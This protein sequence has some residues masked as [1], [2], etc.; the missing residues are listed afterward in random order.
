MSSSPAWETVSETQ[1]HPVPTD[2][3]P[4][5]Q[6][7]MK[8]LRMELSSR[9]CYLEERGWGV[10]SGRVL[11]SMCETPCS[12]CV[13]APHSTP[14]PPRRQPQAI[15]PGSCHECSRPEFVMAVS[16]QP[17][18]GRRQNSMFSQYTPLNHPCKQATKRELGLRQ[19][20]LLLRL[21]SQSGEM[22]HWDH[23]ESADP[24]EVSRNL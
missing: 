5:P 6:N 16:Q 22:T 24:D 12:V 13:Y 7:K 1:S 19:G 2:L 9:A 21:R 3:R 20:N 8:S 4:P 17:L 11:A 18:Q 23:W 14:T 10:L 15:Q